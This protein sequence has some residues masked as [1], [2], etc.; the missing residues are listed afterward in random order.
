MTG[1]FIT[2]ATVLLL[3]AAVIIGFMA[4]MSYSM[5]LKCGWVLAICVIV[6]I[7]CISSL[8]WRVHDIPLTDEQIIDRNRIEIEK[9]NQEIQE[10][11][12]EE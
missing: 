3:I 12:T 10:I 5:G 1:I 6:E 11:E 7:G 9:L 2:I 8:V 4:L